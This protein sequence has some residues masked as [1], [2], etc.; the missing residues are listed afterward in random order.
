M[1]A[2]LLLLTLISKTLAAVDTVY[3]NLCFPLLLLG[4]LEH[5]SFDERLRE[6]GMFS[7]EKRRIWGDLIA[8]LQYLERAYEQVG[9]W[10]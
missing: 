10:F 6:L 5:L 8:A 1:A 4:R 7:L 2:L 9:E 3:T